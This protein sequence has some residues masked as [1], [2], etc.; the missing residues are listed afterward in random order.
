MDFFAGTH[1]S[2]QGDYIEVSFLG[3]IYKA[4]KPHKVSDAI[5]EQIMALIGDGKLKPGEKLPPEREFA[6]LLGV[7]RSS[8][9]EAVTTLSAKGYLEARKRKGIF[10]RSLSSH[11]TYDPLLEMLR[12]D[13]T[14]IIS[15]YELRKDI[16]V[17]GCRR[18]TQEAA[19]EDVRQLHRN[20]MAM[21]EPG[22]SRKK[23]LESDMQFHLT[24]AAM[25]R[26]FLRM[27]VLKDLLELHEDCVG[28][29]HEKIV[30]EQSNATILFR[31]HSAIY[32]AIKAGSPD[33]AHEAM[34]HHLSWVEAQCRVILGT[35]DDKDM[36][37]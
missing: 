34:E 8:L 37:R 28:A 27:S 35:M 16:E 24:I 2:P 36:R 6:E 12:E 23:T 14:R 1:S 3:T 30:R 4:I 18:A 22:A 32:E 7:G 33:Q 21:I 20:L 9:R 25:S 17:T 10:V 13:H 26:N 11:I 5:V 15:L 19:V 31:Q 29:A